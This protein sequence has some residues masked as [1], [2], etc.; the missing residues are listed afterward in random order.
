MLEGPIIAFF[1]VFREK[2]CRQLS[3]MQVIRDAVAADSLPVARLVGTIAC[4]QI[5]FFFT[6]HTFT[7]N[8]F[9]SKSVHRRRYFSWLFLCKERFM[10]QNNAFWNLFVK[11]HGKENFRRDPLVNHLREIPETKPLI[12]IRMADKSAPL[13]T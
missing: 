9:V 3:F 12:V 2:A 7:R 1:R 5:L 4:F 11:G 13:P 6:V 10:K 8:E